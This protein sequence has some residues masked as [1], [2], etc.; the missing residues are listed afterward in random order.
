MRN[1]K[2]ILLASLIAL[3]IVG[4]YSCDN[5]P[6]SGE[7]VETYGLITTEYTIPDLDNTQSSLVDASLEND[8]QLVAPEVYGLSMGEGNDRDPKE[9]KKRR[10]PKRRLHDP[11]RKIM[12]ELNLNEDQKTQL[13][14]LIALHKDCVKEV[15]IALRESE[16]ELL[17]DLKVERQGLVESYRNGEIE[18]EDFIAQMKELN[19]QARELLKNNP[20]RVEACYKLRDC[21]EL[22]FESIAGILDD[23]QKAQWEQ[24]LEEHPLPPCEKDEEG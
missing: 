10:P 16:K 15:L 22:F 23:E 2:S 5:L 4:L 12:H 7:D 9:R 1:S 20:D 13:V 3:F 8:F 14:D 11:F 24:W 17:A 19:T 18:K 6:T 21:R